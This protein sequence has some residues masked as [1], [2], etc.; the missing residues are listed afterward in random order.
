MQT[1]PE[2]YSPLK[3]PSDA[4]KNIGVNIMQEK[5]INAILLYLERTE[6]H[7]HESFLEKERADDILHDIA[8]D[9][10]REQKDTIIQYLAH[11]RRWDYVDGFKK[12]L[13][14]IERGDS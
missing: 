12:A 7:H 8:N 1:L 3:T 4:C 6:R 9:N 2:A 14:I 10:P 11:Y 13:E 5:S